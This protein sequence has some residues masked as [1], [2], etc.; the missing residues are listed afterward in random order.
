MAHWRFWLPSPSPQL[1]FFLQQYQL[2]SFHYLFVMQ[3]SESVIKGVSNLTIS[4]GS[5]NW[6]N[7]ASVLFPGGYSHKF[8]TN[9]QKFQPPTQAFLGE[10][11][12]RPSPQIRAPLNPPAW[13]AT[14]IQEGNLPTNRFP[15]ILVGI[16]VQ[17]QPDLSVL[18]TGHLHA[19][20]GTPS[21][22]HTGNTSPTRAK[23]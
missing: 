14:K 1:F 16:A 11:V 7:L 15:N 3:Q 20:N 10:L 23:K 22:D 8:Q 13:E 19:H 9:P 2:I 18:V 5:L 12:F 4:E 6:K 21:K 17:F